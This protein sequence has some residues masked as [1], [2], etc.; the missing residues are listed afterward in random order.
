MSKQ[1]I[2]FQARAAGKNFQKYLEFVQA[3]RTGKTAM[4]VGNDFV[5][6]DKKTYQEMVDAADF[7]KKLQ[8]EIL[9]DADS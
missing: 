5:V 8:E 7:L 1:N 6:M 2:E 9:K 4:I 3:V